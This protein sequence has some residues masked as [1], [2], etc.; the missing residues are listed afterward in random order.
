MSESLHEMEN[1]K[2]SDVFS[3]G[4]VLYELFHK[5][6]L[7]RSDEAALAA[8]AAYHTLGTPLALKSD[9]KDVIVQML[10]REPH[11]RPSIEV[12][13]SKFAFGHTVMRKGSLVSSGINQIN[14]NV[15]AL[16]QKVDTVEQKLDEAT[17]L[18]L[19]AL[20]SLTSGLQGLSDEVTANA[21]GLEEA[22]R[23]CEGQIRS[24]TRVT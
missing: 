8:L 23:K 4:L 17:R 6:P 22:I 20:Q 1:S 19:A 10:A 16:A 18:T 21:K 3:L 13:L 15:A 14:E 12:C 7:F 2:E 24:G 5:E 11:R 9:T